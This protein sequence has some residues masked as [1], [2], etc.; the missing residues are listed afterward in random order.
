MTPAHGHDGPL[1]TVYVLRRELDLSAWRGGDGAPE[2][3]AA[4]ARDFRDGLAAAGC[5]LIGHIKG[6]IEDDSGGALYFNV[7]RF[8]GA[9]VLRGGVAGAPARLTLNA[10]VFGIAHGD[11]ERAALTALERRLGGRPGGVAGGS[12]ADRG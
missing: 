10:I 1:P 6:V 5:V 11:V 7:T 12:P 8:T 4:F 9:P 2:A 3:V